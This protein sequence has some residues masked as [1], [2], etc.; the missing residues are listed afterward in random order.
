MSAI[1]SY[2]ELEVLC[3]PTRAYRVVN[4][5]LSL[6]EFPVVTARSLAL[7]LVILCVPHFKLVFRDLG[8]PLL[9]VSKPTVGHF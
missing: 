9:A 8:V 5:L 6:I 3:T 7:V 4:P 1:T 2:L